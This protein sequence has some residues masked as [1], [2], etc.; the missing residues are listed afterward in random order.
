MKDI[1]VLIKN[2]LFRNKSLLPDK[3]NDEISRKK[4]NMWREGW[5]N[6]DFISKDLL[7]TIKE[8]KANSIS[9]QPIPSS[10]PSSEPNLIPAK[11]S[12]AI[13]DVYNNNDEIADTND[14]IPDNKNNINDNIFKKK[15]YKW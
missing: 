12:V 1:E 6:K 2:G 13:E 8:I 15:Q 5:K 10:L 7:Q 14:E 4:I 9:V 3:S 11:N